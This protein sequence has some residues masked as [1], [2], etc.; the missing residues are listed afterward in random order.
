M[1]KMLA[2]WHSVAGAE[3]A[4]GREL[5]AQGANLSSNDSAVAG[6]RQPLINERNS[7]AVCW[8]NNKAELLGFVLD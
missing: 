5:A 3:A 4:V 8:I 2:G 6:D 7:L 1:K